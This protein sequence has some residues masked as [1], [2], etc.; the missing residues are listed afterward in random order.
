VGEFSFAAGDFNS[1]GKTDLIVSE[2]GVKDQFGILLGNGDGT[3]QPLTPVKI[4]GPFASG[5]LGIA[6]GDFNSDGLLDFIFQLG[7][8]GFNVYPQTEK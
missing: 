1:D 2:T 3:F 5:E 6:T 8:A 7:G 4:P